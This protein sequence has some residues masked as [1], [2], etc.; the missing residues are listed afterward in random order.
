MCYLITLTIHHIGAIYIRSKCHLIWRNK[1]AIYSWSGLN[2]I[3]TIYHIN[4]WNHIPVIITIKISHI[5]CNN[6]RRVPSDLPHCQDLCRRDAGDQGSRSPGEEGT[7]RNRQEN[8]VVPVKPPWNQHEIPWNHHFCKV[9]DLSS[10]ND[11]FMG[12]HA[13]FMM[14]L[15]GFHSVLV[16]FDGVLIGGFLYFSS[17][18]GDLLKYSWI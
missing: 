2:V 10:K 13:D 16:G 6:L 7:G 8:T 9:V 18:R 17:K 14:F 1:D 3:L 15:M 5:F 4:T 12:F 11:V